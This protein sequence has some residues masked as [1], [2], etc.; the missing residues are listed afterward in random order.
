MST[1]M[2]DSCS[3]ALDSPKDFDSYTVLEYYF[4]H[5]PP[6][7]AYFIH[8]TFRKHTQLPSSRKSNIIKLIVQFLRY[9]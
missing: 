4:G 7:H 9:R 3:P 1:E 6:S 2:C 5:C 8:K